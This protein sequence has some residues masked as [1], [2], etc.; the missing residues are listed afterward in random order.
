MITPGSGSYYAIE[1]HIAFLPF[2]DKDLFTFEF[3]F[4]KCYKVA[5]VLIYK[6]TLKFISIPLFFLELHV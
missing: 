4:L 2:K 3:D 5:S 6:Q 1:P